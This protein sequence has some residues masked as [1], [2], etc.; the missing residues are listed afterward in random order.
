MLI[1]LHLFLKHILHVSF[2][3]VFLLILLP[4]RHATDIEKLMEDVTVLIVLVWLLVVLVVLVVL[5]VLVELV[6]HVA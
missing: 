5:A 6:E 1:V 4:D 3:S 2:G